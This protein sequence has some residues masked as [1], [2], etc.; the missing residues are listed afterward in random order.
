MDDKNNSLVTIEDVATMFSLELIRENR[1]GEISYVC[2]ACGDKR[3]KFSI[4]PVKGVGAC[5]KCGAKYNALTLYEELTDRPYA[6]N[7]EAYR[8]LLDDFGKSG[9]RQA[10]RRTKVV[11]YHE[12]PKANADALDK[13]YRAMLSM[14]TLRP[15]HKA[16]LKKRGFT[17]EA[18][19]GYGFRSTP[20]EGH[21]IADRLIRK[22]IDLN[23]V[24]GFYQR[25]D[26]WML[27]VSCRGFYCPVL[28]AKKRV[29]GFQ[30]RLDKSKGNSKY[31]WLSSAGRT[32]GTSSGAVPT[33]LKGAKDAPVIITEG[34]LKATLVYE[35]LGRRI[36]VVGVP[37]VRSLTG[38]RDA[39][40]A[41]PHAFAVEAYDM[42]K[43]ETKGLKALRLEAERTGADTAKAERYH[44]LVKRENIADAAGVLRQ[45]L[46]DE[47][48]TE[49]FHSLSWDVKDGL[50]KGDF[51][52]LDDFLSAHPE[53]REPLV[54]YLRFLKV[55][56]E[57]EPEAH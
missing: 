19:R 44:D 27:N 38:L 31:L 53:Q 30:V 1:N 45:R 55:K 21:A 32:S 39:M 16:N 28:D 42:D 12:P 26:K 9:L 2:P 13:A 18:I 34:V 35:L 43:A 52:G 47:C 46:H 23:G 20:K 10:P 8:N 41:F 4:N 40:K 24:P 36:S 49:G 22:G 29:V 3:G 5:F 51:K 33:V 57:T 25:D 6:N 17:D 37:G 7:S 50:W 15:E 11:E 54:R 48:G 56:A 14:L